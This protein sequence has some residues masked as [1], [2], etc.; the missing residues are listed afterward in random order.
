MEEKRRDY[1]D[2]MN[3]LGDIEIQIALLG[4]KLDSSYRA[5]NDSHQMMSELI[6]KHNTTIFGN[7]QQ[8]LTRIPT[9]MENLENH[10]KAHSGWDRWLFGVIIGFLSLLL[11]KMYWPQG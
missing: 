5:N 10:L 8:G 2:I 11:G 6:E 1:P 7:G 3:R 4:Q 9:Q